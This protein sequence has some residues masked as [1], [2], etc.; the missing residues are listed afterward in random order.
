[1]ETHQIRQRFSCLGSDLDIQRVNME[2]QFF[3]HRMHM[4]QGQW[5]KR[6]SNSDNDSK[7]HMGNRE[8]HMIQD[9]N[10]QI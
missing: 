6:G 3:D 5:R 2:A 8:E 1:M 4:T 10:T 7:L 9:L